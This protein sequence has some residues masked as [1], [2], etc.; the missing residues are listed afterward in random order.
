MTV[1][2]TQPDAPAIAE[3]LSASVQRRPPRAAR[4]LA[5]LALLVVALLLPLVA[6]ELALRLFGPFLPGNY[7]TGSFQANHPVYGRFHAPNFDGWIRSSEFVSRMKT[8]SLGLR[9]DEVAMPKPPG[10]YRILVI[11]DS[12]VQGSQVSVG[13]PFTEVLERAL[14]AL[15]PHQGRPQRYE[16][17]NAGVGGWGPAEEYLWLK[18]EGLRLQPDVVIQQ[19]YLGNDISD[20]GC[21]IIGQDKLKHKV[22]FYFD[23]QGRL[24]QD[25]LRLRAERQWDPIRSPLRQSFALFNVL[26]TGVF[27]KIDAGTD[28]DRATNWQSN[29]Y[30][31]A[32][33]PP[34]RDQWEEAW[35]IA[36]ALIA[37]A[38]REAEAGGAKYVLTAA[39]SI[40]QIY[41]DEWDQ[42]VAENKLKPDQWD[43]ER[44]NQR[45]G[46]IARSLGALYLDLGP[47]FRQEAPTSAR[48]FYHADL[49]FTPAGH[50]VVAR[51]LQAFL[52][53]NGLVP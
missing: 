18:N 32:K 23:Q 3:P 34:R 19:L 27:E 15:P 2:P 25:E 46:E 42:A 41:P 52:Q 53:A 9:D 11:G 5:R 51:H 33:S 13:Q 37:S 22:C 35:Q 6:L 16:V 29:M 7:R 21:K 49:H 48:L 17:V 44:P 14:N 10:T 1:T 12:F 38:K 30:V 40:F 50:E 4:W 45:L 28:E 24:Y 31:Y 47:A 39:P 8:N 43:L 26:E 20:A 36:A